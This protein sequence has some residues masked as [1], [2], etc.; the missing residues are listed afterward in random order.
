MTGEVM[1][2]HF[3]VL[4]SAARVPDR[5]PD[6]GPF[7]ATLTRITMQR[8]LEVL[9]RIPKLFPILVVGGLVLAGVQ[10]ATATGVKAQPFGYGNLTPAQKAHV[11]G[12]L[13]LEL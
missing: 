1:A 6:L 8:S 13:S 2:W 10:F 5:V 11:S 4:R 7:H 3:S 9:M 12:L